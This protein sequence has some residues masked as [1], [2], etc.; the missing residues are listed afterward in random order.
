MTGGGKNPDAQGGN[1]SSGV[2]SGNST[3]RAPRIDGAGQFSLPLATVVPAPAN[4]ARVPARTQAPPGMY[5]S[6]PSFPTP[7]TPPSSPKAPGD[8]GEYRPSLT[9]L[10]Q[11]SQTNSGNPSSPPIDKAAPKIDSPPQVL[12][13][14]TTADRESPAP[15]NPVVNV[16]DSP[17]SSLYP[18]PQTPPPPRPLTSLGLWRH[19]QNPPT[20]PSART[21]A[22]QP[23]EPQEVPAELRVIF[24]LH[25]KTPAT[26]TGAGVMQRKGSQ[27]GAGS[28]EGVWKLADIMT[29][30]SIPIE[31]FKQFPEGQLFSITPARLD[32]PCPLQQRF[33]GTGAIS[34]E[35]ADKLCSSFGV[36]GLLDKLNGVLGTRYQMNKNLSSLLTSYVNDNDCDFGQAY[37]EVRRGWFCDVNRLQDRLRRSASQD[38]A[39]RRRA[40]NPERGLIVQPRT[41]PRRVWDLYSNRVLDFWVLLTTDMPKNLWAVSHSWVEDK[42]RKL[43]RTRINGYEWAI[44]IP[45][46]VELDQVRIELLNLGA[47]YVWLDVLCLRQQV[48]EKTRQRLGWDFDTWHN[49]EVLRQEEWRLDVPTIGHVF[50]CKPSQVVITYFSGLGRPFCVT[51]EMF[52]ESRSWLNRVWTMQETT[53]NWLLGGLMPEKFVAA[54][55]D[56]DLPSIFHAR[57]CNL[58]TV[59]A[60]DPP[61]LFAL[62]KALQGRHGTNP[63]D[64]VSAL[65]LLLKCPA[66]PIYDIRQPCEG[67][68]DQLLQQMSRKHRTDLLV[69][70]LAAGD[71]PGAKW[72]PSWAQLM[73]KRS[74]PP[75]TRPIDYSE[76][77][78]LNCRAVPRDVVTGPAV[79]YWNYAYVI[80]SCS[81]THEPDGTYMHATLGPVTHFWA[82]DYKTAPFRIQT[83][84]ARFDP[85]VDYAAVGVAD[86]EYWVLGK[87]LDRHPDLE[88]VT[89]EKIAVFQIPDAKERER[90][91]HLNPGYSD[92]PIHYL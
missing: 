81:F 49:I 69:T 58:L 46:D 68:W 3:S 84:G 87:I 86:L 55:G 21:G 31:A 56:M 12:P 61:D 53:P 65:G 32:G 5:S 9:P 26:T 72:R 91:W 4:E 80:E 48:D 89:F 1:V 37:G 64:R 25:C 78:L 74:I 41:P 17:V 10:H 2:R 16:V 52:A 59:L 15:G 13:S 11:V 76:G 88:Y 83:T 79:V 66:L 35:L 38:L 36:D 92:T 47:E 90:L 34:N 57:I 28:L 85:S 20:I 51:P 33:K 77:E 50:R 82:N 70:C 19:L 60:Q 6:I 71:T 44:P 30:S 8:S 67:A 40:I 24:G 39:M 63:I 22:P 45:H 14:R 62:A 18:L 29:Y 43:V 7:P 75:K 42:E 23:L 27:H 73:E 54:K